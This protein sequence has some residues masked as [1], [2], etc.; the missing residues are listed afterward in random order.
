MSLWHDEKGARRSPDYPYSLKHNIDIYKSPNLIYI[1]SSS[2]FMCGICQK[3]EDQILLSWGWSYIKE[4]GGL[5]PINPEVSP[6]WLN[7]LS[8][9]E[10]PSADKFPENRGASHFPRCHVCEHQMIGSEDLV[11][12]VLIQTY[13]HHFSSFVCRNFHFLLQ[14][15]SRTRTSI[16]LTDQQTA[17]KLGHSFTIPFYALHT[18]KHSNIQWLQHLIFISY[19]CWRNAQNG[20]GSRDIIHLRM[21]V[22]WSP[23]VSIPCS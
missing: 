12:F 23:T 6:C 15:I 1:L 9:H 11:L 3:T 22:N 5:K 2:K 20:A 7:W 14:R 8:R 17:H 18:P 21:F 19:H 10:N 13:S 16:F 4:D